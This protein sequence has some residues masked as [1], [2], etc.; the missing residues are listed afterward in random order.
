M[1][2]S[3]Q[4]THQL[5][6]YDYLLPKYRI[7]QYPASPRDSSELLLV[8]RDQQKLADFRFFQL[9]ELLQPED[10]LVLN[11]T[12][13]IP[14]RLRSDCGEVLL[15]RSTGGKNC[16]DAMIHPGKHFSPGT[17]VHFAGDLEATVL[18]H[19]TIGRFLQFHGDLDA[20]L[21]KYGRIPL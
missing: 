7:A 20:H 12:K 4:K 21:Q 15:V 10:L 3:T 18:S 6:T 11:N 17:R 5:E 9:A 1:N 16:W 19:S 13:V 14:A 2:R 8:S